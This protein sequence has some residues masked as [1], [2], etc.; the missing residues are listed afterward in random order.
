MSVKIAPSVLAADCT[1]LGLE[2]EKI[3]RAGAEYLHI[4]I[5]DGHFVPNLSFAPQLVKALRPITKMVFDVHLMMSHP[6]DYCK[7][8]ADAGAD[9]ITVHYEAAEDTQELIRWA[10]QIHSYGIRAGVSIKP[11]TDPEQLRGLL[12]LFDLILVMSVEPGFG[13]QS[14]MEMANGKLKKLTQM[15]AEENPDAELEVDGGINETTA[16]MAAE[17]GARVLVAGSS[18]FGSADPAKAV[19]DLRDAA[20]KAMAKA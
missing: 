7:A 13:G 19:A 4:D 9:I 16:A 2:V 10:E 8:F 1:K 6:G 17:A 20:E 5:M 11:A 15:L 3:E 14:Y 18:V 12:S